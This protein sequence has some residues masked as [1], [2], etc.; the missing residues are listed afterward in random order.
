VEGIYL[1]LTKLHRSEVINIGSGN[2]ISMQS[3][4]NE[5]RQYFPEMEVREEESRTGDVVQTWADIHKAKD[6]LGYR[7][8]VSFENGLAETVKWAKENEAF[9]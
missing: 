8:K 6:L 1:T 9:L 4:L 3:L 2:P 7:P 5:L